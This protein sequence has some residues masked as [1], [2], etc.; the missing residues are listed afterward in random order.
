MTPGH[1]EVDQLVVLL[2]GHPGPSPPQPRRAGHRLAAQQVRVVAGPTEGP[3]PAPPGGAGGAQRG[4]GG[5]LLLALPAD[6]GGGAGPGELAV[7]AL[8][9]LP[10]H[11]RGILLLEIQIISWSGGKE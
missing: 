9:E 7:Q 10:H 5:Q 8:L 11:H 6:H 4:P 2:T 1:Q 3:A